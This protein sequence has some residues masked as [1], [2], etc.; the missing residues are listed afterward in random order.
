MAQ[1]FYYELKEKYVCSEAIF[2]RQNNK[3]IAENE[4][5]KAAHSR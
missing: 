3:T 4:V 2:V 1:H 5:H